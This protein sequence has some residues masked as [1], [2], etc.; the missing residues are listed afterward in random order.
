MNPHAFTEMFEEM[1][2]ASRFSTRPPEF[3]LTHPL[4]TNRIVDATNAARK[5]P[6][7]TFAEN[8][9][10]QLARSRAILL[11]EQTP[12]QAIKRFQNELSGFSSSE[13]A[14]RYGL[15]VALID[16]KQ[17]DKASDNLAQLTEKYPTNN[18]LLIAR[19]DILAGQGDINRAI[20]II[21]EQLALTPKHYPLQIQLSQLFID[22]GDFSAAVKWL[23]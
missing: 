19:S 5:Y 3:L 9:D 7:Q 10:Y 21:K 23:V 4:T 8:I 16:D 14:S 18:T 22:K 20:N 2:R 6:K 12:Q 13:E 1:D 11:M 15:A 17:F